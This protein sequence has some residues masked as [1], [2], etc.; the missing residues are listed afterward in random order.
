MNPPCLNARASIAASLSVTGE[1]CMPARKDLWRLLN[2]KKMNIPLKNRIPY[3]IGGYSTSRSAR[4]ANNS[5]L[6]RR[7]GDIAEI[8]K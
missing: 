4:D 1:T 3:T 8:I 7:R 6:A 5:L 2:A